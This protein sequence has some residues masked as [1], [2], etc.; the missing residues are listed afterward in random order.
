MVGA[1]KGRVLAG[2][3]RKNLCE[4][5]TVAKAGFFGNLLSA[6]PVWAPSNWLRRRA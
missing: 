4:V 1:K 3:R 5:I 6:R 2:Y